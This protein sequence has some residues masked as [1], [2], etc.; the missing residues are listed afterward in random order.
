MRKREIDRHAETRV[1]MKEIHRE[2][3]RR[4]KREKRVTGDEKVIRTCIK[5]Q[6][7]GV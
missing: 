2:G 3:G 5:R 1:R 6:I 4:K 7:Y